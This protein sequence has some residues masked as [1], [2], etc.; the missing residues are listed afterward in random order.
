MDNQ[1]W[2]IDQYYNKKYL[3]PLKDFVNSGGRTIAEPTIEEKRRTDFLKNLFIQNYGESA[4]DEGTFNIL[5]VGCGLANDVIE[6]AKLFPNIKF[7]LVEFADNAIDYLRNLSENAKTPDNIEVY[8]ANFFGSRFSN[9]SGK[10]FDYIIF[11]GVLDSYDGPEYITALQTAKN[12]LQPW[13]TI[14]LG[15][16]AHDD[17]F[18]FAQ[19]YEKYEGKYIIRN[20]FGSD[21]IEKYMNAVDFDHIAFIIYDHKVDRTFKLNGGNETNNVVRRYAIME[22]EE[23][24]SENIPGEPDDGESLLTVNQVHLGTEKNIHL[25]INIPEG[26]R[27]DGVDIIYKSTT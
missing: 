13:G 14:V 25:T 26:Y 8:R 20:I 2:E 12:L 18:E 23:V 24:H 22:M 4:L 6:L 15:Y 17:V 1:K 27:F 3:K 10:K 5:W 21:M 16:L 7:H 9:Y 19:A 11:N